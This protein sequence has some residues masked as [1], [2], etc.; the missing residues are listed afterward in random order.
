MVQKNRNAAVTPVQAVK[1]VV[2]GALVSGRS[3]TLLAGGR[4]DNLVGTFANK[5][6][7]AVGM[8]VG[9]DRLFAALQE[10]KLVPEIINI[11][12]DARVILVV[13]DLTD[14]RIDQAHCNI[15]AQVGVAHAIAFHPRNH[16][17]SPARG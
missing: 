9:I 16:I 3:F 11:T 10:L 13:I 12:H 17:V 1:F 6:I 14:H 5:S 7:P 2:D 8:S 15:P 4:Y